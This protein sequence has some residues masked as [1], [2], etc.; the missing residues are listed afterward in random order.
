MKPSLHCLTG[1]LLLLSLSHVQA[2]PAQSKSIRIVSGVV[3]DVSGNI[4]PY[5]TVGVED[6]N[7]GTNT[8]SEGRF[9]LGLPNGNYTLTISYV[10]YQ[11]K[12]VNINV[13][14]SP[15]EVAIGLQANA[16]QL[17]DVTIY[18]QLTRGQAKA[19]NIQKLSPNIINVVDVEQFS[20]YPDV[21]AAE[22][23][24]R[25]PGISITRDQ[26]EGEFVQIRGIPE[27]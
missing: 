14:D 2:Q 5:A 18:G 7:Q 9:S 20:R 12:K 26:G 16:A 4:L 19:L 21:S 10:G 11:G 25:L 23:V 13:G 27:Q 24:Q 17:A 8:D 15:V 6:T 22:T 1:F 3:T